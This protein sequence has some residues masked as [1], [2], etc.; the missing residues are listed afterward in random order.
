MQLNVKDFG[1]IRDGKTKDTLSLQ[2][3]I[4]RCN[5]LGG[6]EVFVPGGDYLVGAIVLR[7]N[8]LLRLAT[9]ATLLGSS[10]LIDYPLTQIRWKGR[11]AN[12]R[13]GLISAMN[14]ENIGITGTGRIMS[15]TAIKG[16]IDAQTG[17]RNPALLEFTGC[18][19]LRVEDCTTEQNDM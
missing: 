19:N 3:A 11:W 10:D 13:I 12:S 14:A 6:G 17:L 9:E 4:D 7:S 5:I 2:Q 1:A 15:S 8:T 18:R 16:Y